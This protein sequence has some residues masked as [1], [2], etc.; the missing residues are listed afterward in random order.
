MPLL[1]KKRRRTAVHEV[2]G[3]FRVIFGSVRRHFAWLESA[4][5]VGGAQIWA[6]AVMAKRPGLRVGDLAEALSIHQSTASNLAERLI[7][8]GLAK[9]RRDGGDQRVVH[10]ELSARGRSLL[11]RAPRPLQGVL[12]D[13]LERLPAGTLRRL[14][15]DLGVLVRS[16]HAKDDR[17]A[18]LPLA[19]L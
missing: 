18:Y 13:A 8:Q 3:A 7:R 9:R 2:L 19:D 10:L 15:A 17:A 4:C 12:P 6:L 5:G 16:L 1:P 14:K 11:K